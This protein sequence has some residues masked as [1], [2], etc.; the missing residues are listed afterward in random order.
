M[1][2]ALAVLLLAVALPWALE[3]FDR[4]FY[5]SFASRVMI[6]AIA[7]TSLN[8][9]L[10]YGGMISFGHAAFVGTG[11]YAA[12][13]L[14]VEGVTSAWIAWPVAVL[15]AAAAAWLIGAASLRTRGVY[16]I[17]I[18]LA[19]AQ[20]AFY[21]VNSMKA[22]G[23]DEGLTLTGRPDLGFSLGNE[24]AFY[25]VVLGF[26]S[27]ILFLLHRLAR[28]RFGRVIQAMRENAP[29]A[30]AIG[31]PVFRYQ[32]ACFVI[33]G[34]VGGLAG[35]LLA[36]H[37]KY[38]NP[39]VLHWTQSGTLMVMVILGGVGRLWGGVLGAAVLLTLEHLVADYRIGWL[40]SLAPNYQQHASLAVGVVLLVVVLFA[41]HGI[42]GLMARKR[43][44]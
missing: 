30:E 11:A 19:F 6:Y 14:F 44:A 25:Y 36:A 3:Y 34:A 5:V 33:A 35:A 28:S 15:A 20:M 21:L 37:G 8:L 13:I 23:G 38:V 2:R 18:T 24:I 41:P 7:A 12:S 1:K 26:L 40:A 17:M 4:T 31:F 22:Y 29:R 27:L 10:G 43:H 42:A 16:F 32:L 9:V 39:G